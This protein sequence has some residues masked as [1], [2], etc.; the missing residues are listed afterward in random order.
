MVS[1]LLAALG[2]RLLDLERGLIRL[3]GEG[4]H[5]FSLELQRRGDGA[6]QI[7]VSFL[8]AGDPIEG[9]TLRL[10]GRAVGAEQGDMRSAGRGRSGRGLEN[11]RLPEAGDL[12]RGKKP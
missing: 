7:E 10:G 2:V 5:R 4:E 11:D 8:S 1:S 6:A 3:G 12:R 9:G